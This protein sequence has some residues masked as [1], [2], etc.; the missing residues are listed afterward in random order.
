MSPAG[1]G[2]GVVTLHE[3]V[4]KSKEAS[5][6]YVEVH[7]VGETKYGFTVSTDLG[8]FAT[9]AVIKSVIHDKI[10]LNSTERK[11]CGVK[12]TAAVIEGDEETNKTVDRTTCALVACDAPSFTMV[13]ALS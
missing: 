2:T 9:V 8:P 4:S 1:C 7:V 12:A 5:H 3:G 6:S 13:S 11:V 10:A